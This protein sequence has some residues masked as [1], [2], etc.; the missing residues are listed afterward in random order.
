MDRN[1]INQLAQLA[2]SRPLASIEITHTKRKSKYRVIGF[3]K[4][5]HASKW[6]PHILYRCLESDV[7]YSRSAGE[8]TNFKK[9]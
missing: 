7:L 3:V 2:K 8:F 9:V 5:D 1:R 6:F 4:S